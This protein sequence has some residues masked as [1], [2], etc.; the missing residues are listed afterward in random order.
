MFRRPS[1]SLQASLSSSSSFSSAVLPGDRESLNQASSPQP[2][3]DIGKYFIRWPFVVI[4]VQTVKFK[5]STLIGFTVIFF[6]IQ[7]LN[8]IFFVKE[9]LKHNDWVTVLQGFF[10]IVFFISLS[11]VIAN[12]TELP[13][14][15]LKYSPFESLFSQP[16][17]AE[18]ETKWLQL[19]L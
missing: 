15:A 3:P 5:C 16:H 2:T 8:S 13:H 17:Y 19:E 18:E 10:L 9:D 1:L 12:I 4:E 14:S 6:H 7:R 11:E